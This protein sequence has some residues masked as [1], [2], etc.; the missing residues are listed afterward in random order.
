LY[1][2]IFC[3]CRLITNQHRRDRREREGNKKRIASSERMK[4]P[5][6]PF[7][8]KKSKV[9]C[10]IRNAN[11][12]RAP[13]TKNDS[14]KK[15]FTHSQTVSLPLRLSSPLLQSFSL[16]LS[17]SLSFSPP[18]LP[19]PSRLLLFRPPLSI[20]S[21][22]LYNMFL[23]IYIFISYTF[24]SVAFFISRHVSKKVTLPEW[25]I[26]LAGTINSHHTKITSRTM[27]NGPYFYRNLSLSAARKPYTQQYTRDGGR[28]Y[29]SLEFL[30]WNG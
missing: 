22:R 17:L 4:Y 25:H 1:Y 5:W 6:H 19:P 29:R 9:F 21:L 27:N 13:S 16:S 23:Y 24:V 30:K 8:Y 7:L 12:V 26:F 20:S 10:G 11:H 3:S 14:R 2:F 18:Y 15:I 28:I